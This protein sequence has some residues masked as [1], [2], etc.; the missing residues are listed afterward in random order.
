MAA[1]GDT[2]KPSI[3]CSKKCENVNYGPEDVDIFAN[4][5]MRSFAATGQSA[6]IRIYEFMF[7]HYNVQCAQILL[8]DDDFKCSERRCNLKRTLDRLL[9]YHVVPIVNENDALSTS[10]KLK[11]VRNTDSLACLVA[12]EMGMELTILLTDGDNEGVYKEKSCD[13]GMYTAT[14]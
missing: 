13:N 12:T 5:A 4:A 9:S 8:T 6:L 10:N 7:S 1:T 3:W 2:T 11:I 14:F